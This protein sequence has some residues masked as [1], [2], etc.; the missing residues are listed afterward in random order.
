MLEKR[1][2]FIDGQR[3]ESEERGQTR[4]ERRDGGSRVGK[5]TRT[6]SAEH[7]DEEGVE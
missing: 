4:K 2:T 1:N 5:E 3:R 6:S 7:V